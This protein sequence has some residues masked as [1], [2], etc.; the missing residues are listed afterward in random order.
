MQW[1][2]RSDINRNACCVAYF[3]S[4]IIQEAK[5]FQLPLLLRYYTLQIYFNLHT[6]YQRMIDLLIYILYLYTEWFTKNAHQLFFSL[7]ISFLELLNILKNYIL[8]L[9]TFFLII[10]E[11]SAEI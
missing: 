4:N 5:T 6:L 11:Y 10:K 3:D 2:Y 1:R 9:S 8:K 7:K